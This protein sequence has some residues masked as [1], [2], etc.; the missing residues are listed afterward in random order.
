MHGENPAKYVFEVGDFAGCK[1]GVD[2]VM[3]NL[4]RGQIWC[5]DCRHAVLGYLLGM[6][7]A[8]MY[9]VLQ[10]RFKPGEYAED[11]EVASWYPEWG[12]AQIG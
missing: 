7:V 12:T 11:G 10:P 2:K 6:S 4:K 3:V 5:S 9:V 8:M 1:R